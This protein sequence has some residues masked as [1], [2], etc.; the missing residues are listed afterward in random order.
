MTYSER[1]SGTHCIVAPLMLFFFM[2]S[3]VYIIPCDCAPHHKNQNVIQSSYVLSCQQLP[4]AIDF[5]QSSLFRIQIHIYG[6]QRAARLADRCYNV[7]YLNL[8]RHVCIT[9]TLPRLP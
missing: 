5:E 2:K 7:L 9:P 4:F 1:C 3:C 6:V 8:N